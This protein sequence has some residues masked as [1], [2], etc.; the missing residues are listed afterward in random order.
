MM[1]IEGGENHML[2]ERL[3]AVRIK[4]ELSQ[5]DVAHAT[6]LS[7]QS[8]SYYEKDQRS[9]DYETLKKLST[10]L[11]V[12]AA[13]LLEET[14]EMIPPLTKQASA[15]AQPPHQPIQVDGYDDL[16]ATDQQK[17]VE[18]IKLLKLQYNKEFGHK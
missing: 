1:N 11:N 13:Y 10:F 8:Y 5:T 18:Y 4:K 16:L 14:D 9:P 7:P 17:V 6:G 3:K 12:S 15:Q 2:G